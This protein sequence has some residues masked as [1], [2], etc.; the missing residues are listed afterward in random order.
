MAQDLTKYTDYAKARWSD[1]DH[2]LYDLLQN[3]DTAGG[4]GCETKLDEIITILNTPK[5]VK[6]NAVQIY[7]MAP[8]DILNFNANTISGLKFINVGAVVG[9]ILL[10]D[11]AEFPTQPGIMYDI[12]QLSENMPTALDIET[13]FSQHTVIITKYPSVARQE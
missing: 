5:D 1:T 13:K 11:D 7:S 3:Q 12:F 8:Y 2:L 10:N 6:H 4:C 9:K